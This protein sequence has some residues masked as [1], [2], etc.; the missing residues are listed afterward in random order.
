MNGFQVRVSYIFGNV[1]GLSQLETAFGCALAV[2]V[3]VQI[4][5]HENSITLLGR[6]H[7]C[8]GR[9]YDSVLKIQRT[10]LEGREKCCLSEWLEA[11]R[12]ICFGHHVL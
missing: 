11:S 3:N 6:S 4:L 2:I 1:S 8:Q 10:Q 5:G 12:A 9:L 7:A